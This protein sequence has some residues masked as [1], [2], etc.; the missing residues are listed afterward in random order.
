[1]TWRLLSIL[2]LG[3]ACASAR[4]QAQFLTRE[5]LKK[6][7]TEP[8]EKAL[9]EFVDL[10][11]VEKRQQLA[12]HMENIMRGV[13][14]AV[15]LTAE[16]KAA[17]VEKTRAAVDAAVQAWKPEVV[18]AMRTYLSRTTEG[19]AKRQ[20]SQWK[21]NQAGV[22]EPV[23]NW[24]P[25]QESPVWQA[26]LGGVIGADRLQT[27]QKAYAE[28]QQ[29]VGKV[30]SGYVERWTREARAPMNEDVKARVELMKARL[31]LPE[32][33][34]AALTK[35]ADALLDRLSEAERRRGE[36]MLRPMP[37]ESR[38]K[39][40]NRTGNYLR[41][42]RPRGDHLD[43]LW[44]ETAATVLP[45]DVMVRWEKIAKEERQKEAVELAEVIK[46]SE[47]YLR[48]QME[49]A[50][51]TEVEGLAGD[52]GLDKARQAR[53]KKLADEAVEAS[54]KEAHKTWMLQVRNYSAAERKRARGHVSFGLSDELHARMSPTWK[55][56]LQKLLQEDELRR[57]ERENEG[58]QQRA[59]AAIARACITELD[60][61]V[62]FGADQRAKLEP[63]VAATLDPLVEQRRQEYWS[64]STQM[65]FQYAAK[66]REEDLRA[67]LDEAQLRRWREAIATGAASSQQ[68]NVSL[69]MG[70]QP[71]VPDM[72]AAI[73]EHLYKMFTAERK[74]VAGQMMPRV[75]EAQRV[76]GLPEDVVD[77]LGVAAKGAVE[78][79]LDYWRMNTER[80]VRQAVLSATPRNIVQALAGTERVSFGRSTENTPESM[81]VWT[82]A[83]RAELNAAQLQRLKAVAMQRMSYRLQAMAAMSVGEMDRRRRLSGEQC[84]KL[85][86]QVQK[87]LA[88]YLPD[89]ERY[90]SSNW[91]LQY[92]YA[93]VPMA[94]IKEKEMQAILTP[95]QWK[96]CKERDLPDAMQYWE[97]IENNHKN[98]LKQGGDAGQIFNGGWL[99]D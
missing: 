28:S 3:L 93:M 14:Q 69:P 18:V 61:T 1:M 22:D 10:C 45:Q 83:L 86:A 15:K 98:R 71:E 53:L 94:G 78:D 42:D 24:T 76:L 7:L 68:R 16:E 19:I 90:M 34:A 75:E 92:Y 51:T 97:G 48:Q 9:A 20:I 25:P 84:A 80:Y 4:A 12:A 30:I 54:L 13:D 35:A 52:L 62:M 8:V 47:L 31:E 99:V 41:F 44:T 23:E 67:I 63:L 87:I 43:K 77:R 60:E 82:T 89:L 26:A 85:E 70:E 40:I 50:M 5:E 11:A 72:E 6:P 46:P 37:D 2:V 58:R 66:L 33:T 29:E 59:I 73:S 39:I 32:E 17:M 36:A 65:L 81:E 57:L 88:E 27:W 64:Y 55:D 95:Q 49:M 21:P 56:G 74:K 96:L 79:S 91:Y 38:E